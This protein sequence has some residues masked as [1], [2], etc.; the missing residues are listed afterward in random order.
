MTDAFSPSPPALASQEWAA[1][2]ELKEDK[3]IVIARAD[4]ENATVIMDRKIYENK[5]AAK[6]QDTALL[7]STSN[8]E[9]TH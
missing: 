5:I 8:F 9:H 3:G 6:L 4:K 7:Y 1:V 2:K